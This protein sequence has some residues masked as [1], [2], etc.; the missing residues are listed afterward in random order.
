MVRRDRMN[1]FPAAIV[2]RVQLFV[3]LELTAGF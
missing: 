3:D 2:R 1:L